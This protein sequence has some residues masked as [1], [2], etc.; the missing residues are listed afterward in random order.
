MAFAGEAVVRLLVEGHQEGVMVHFLTA[1]LQRL[2]LQTQVVAVVEALKVRL[3]PE[4][5]AAQ[6]LSAS[7]GLNKENKNELC[8]HQQQHR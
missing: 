5:L 4:L 1:Q 6:V 2:L 7:G 3:L 8:T